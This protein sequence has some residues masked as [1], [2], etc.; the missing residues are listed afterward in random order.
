MGFFSWLTADTK[1]TIANTFTD[2][3]R[4]E[5]VYLL[6]PDGSKI[7]EPFYEGYGIFG[8]QNAYVLLGRQNSERL[9]VTLQTDEEAFSLGVS[10]DCGVVYIHSETTE[11]WHIFHTGAHCVLGGRK[12]H[13]RFNEYSQSWEWKSTRQLKSVCS[14]RHRLPRGRFLAA[15]VQLRSRG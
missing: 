1:E 13:S 14:S 6:C 2:K 7:H 12:V 11:I 8:E 9:G 5:G 4:A 3:H 15:Q 10:L